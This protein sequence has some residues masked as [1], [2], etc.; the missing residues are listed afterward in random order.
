MDVSEAHLKRTAEKD[1]AWLFSKSQK[2]GSIDL[3]VDLHCLKGGN[4]DSLIAFPLA[5]RLGFWPEKYDVCCFFVRF[6][7]QGLKVLTTHG[8]SL[9]TGSMISLCQRNCPREASILVNLQEDRNCL[10]AGKT[11][12]SDKDRAPFH[13]GFPFADV[14]GKVL[15]AGDLSEVNPFV[16]LALQKIFLGNCAQE[17]L[18]A[19]PPISRD[20]SDFLETRGIQVV[21]IEGSA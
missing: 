8:L 1:P 4:G 19:T 6:V 10:L 18:F 7:S 21:K 12:F 17:V 9:V 3:V 11:P 14:R 2:A 15:L 20:Y 16:A 5:V 13:I